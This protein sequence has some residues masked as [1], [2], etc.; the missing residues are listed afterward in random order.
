MALPAPTRAAARTLV[1]AL[2]LIALA[3]L[4]PASADAATAATLS[5]T[6]AF[7]AG[8]REAGG[9]PGTA[10]TYTVRNTGD[11]TLT[12]GSVELTGADAG[13]FTLVA[14][15][16]S[17][18]TA[19]D[20]LDPQ[21]TCTVGVAFA[22]SS[23]G[24]F[25]TTLSVTTNGPTL[26][27]A[28]ITGTGRNLDVSEATLDFGQLAVGD[29][30]A[31]KTVTIRNLDATPYTLGNVTI[32]GSAASQFVEESDT[33][34][35]A[36]LAQNATCTVAV[37]FRPTSAGPKAAAVNIASYGP[38]PV[39][40]SG[41]AVEGAAAIAPATRDFGRLATGAAS[42]PQSFVLSNTSNR[43]LD[44]DLVALTGPDSRHFSL[45]SDTC[46]DSTVDAGDDC[47][48]QASFTP[49]AAG[50][51]TASLRI[52]TSAAGPSV[53]ARLSGRA[54]SGGTDST[55][56]GDAPL[57]SQPLVRLR[58]D[59][60]DTAGA[61][62]ATGS[63]DVNNDGY[64]DVLAGAPL[65]SRT[66]AE[67]SWE[68]A[69][70][71]HLGESAVGGADLADPTSGSTVRIEGEQPDS[72][73]G[74]G[75]ACAGDVNDDGFDDVAVGAW[76]YEYAGRPSGTAAPRGV[77]YVVHGSA[78]FGSRS[79]ID[80]G[81]L[82]GQG[83]R[84]E[85]AD[86]DAFD[87]L[88]YKV[89]GLGDVDGDGLDDLG[90]MANTGD[91]LGR[92]NNGVTVVL[93]GRRETSTQTVT[94]DDTSPSLLTLNGG[95]SGQGNDVAP[96]GDVDGDGQDDIG[97]A[98]LT[99]VAFGRSAA[100]QVWAVSGDKR[101]SVDLAASDAALFSVG[102]AFAS[103]RAGAA[104]RSAGD[105]NGDGVGDLA[106]GADSTS[107]ANSDA[108]YVV[109]GADDRGGALLDG[110]DLGQDGYRILGAPGSSTGYGVD[111]AG[112]VN[113]D[114]YDDL[115]VGAYSADG[116]AGDGAGQAHVVFGQPDPSELPENDASS[117]LTPANANDKTRYLR[118]SSLAPEQGSTLPGMTAGERF[119]RQAAFVGDV[120]R[121][122][123]G[124]LAFGADQA[125]RH[126]R[127]AAGEVTVALMPA[128]A[129][130][131][132]VDPEEPGNGPGGGS[133]GPRPTTPQGPGDD[134]ARPTPVNR[135][136][137]GVR[138]HRVRADRRGRLKLKLR[139]K[140]AAARCTGSARLVLSGRRVGAVRFA[141]PTGRTQTVTLR[142]SRT[143]RRA[144]KRRGKLSGRL[145]VAAWVDGH[146]GVVRR[147]VR[148]VA[149][150][151]R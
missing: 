68:G 82:S 108:A 43:P 113:A 134:P 74:T 143:I 56:F 120:D 8:N 114:G 137:P 16:C 81:R 96:I 112:D 13:Q 104:V 39:A 47:T 98:S 85:G 21:E 9:G 128:P 33:C 144:L 92:T 122:G 23:T 131:A 115:V 63:C 121:N 65:W 55:V 2:I 129:P 124:D 25:S 76:A 60:G 10:R 88:G 75:V 136:I 58:G 50:W 17:A 36:S 73:T 105:V 102:G 132:P 26:T 79:P 44:V 135:S 52:A 1:A 89:A 59:G 67:L 22:P 94:Q 111:T 18:R 119:G 11:E 46:S 80:L 45:S 140:G 24:A 70:Y 61:A 125:F 106:I 72:Q 127:T 100:G 5:P 103:H 64:A 37:R 142:M 20:P 7:A 66:P 151:P 90:V 4:A 71:V 6:T 51:K 54:G 97:I 62:V 77:A 28:A 15:E 38:S 40:L 110:S 149:V 69:V 130:A 30:S 99:A 109:Y 145:T 14:D 42:A 57:A 93:P 34:S 118:L 32:G 27:S 49:G 141:A 138:S 91:S 133:N 19:A 31:T 53:T 101:G 3:S 84:I 126:G 123:A 117:G 95:T 107:A 148:I 12:V 29:N 116:P 139:C 86:D 48:V 35:G 87:H 150:K 78:D 83:Y 41:D 147:T 146:Q